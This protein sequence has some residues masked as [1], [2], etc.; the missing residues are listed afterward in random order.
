MSSGKYWETETPITADTGKNILRYFDGAG[1]LQASMP[2]WTDLNGDHTKRL[3][4]CGASPGQ[5]EGI[6]DAA[7]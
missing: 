2:N 3:R 1:K 4:E 7:K 6:E 5:R